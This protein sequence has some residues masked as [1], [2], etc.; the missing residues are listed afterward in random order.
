MKLALIDK[1][2][3][4]NLTMPEAIVILAGMVLVGF[5]AWLL[6]RG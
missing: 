5:V 6:L 4:A 3:D 2:T 1:M